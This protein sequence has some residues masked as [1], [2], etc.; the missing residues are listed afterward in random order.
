MGRGGKCSCLIDPNPNSACLGAAAAEC[1]VACMHSC[2]LNPKLL[3]GWH[4]HSL[5]TT[6]VDFVFGCPSCPCAALEQAST[7]SGSTL[8]MLARCLS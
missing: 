8:P 5:L 3:V 6:S 2:S 7:L 1:L 4:G